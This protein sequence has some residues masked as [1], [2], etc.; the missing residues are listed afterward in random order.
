ML[1]R[2]AIGLLALLLASPA[3]AQTNVATNNLSATI[4]TGNTF[5]TI[6]GAATDPRRSLTIQN[7]NTNGDNCWVFLGS[8]AA[9]KARAIL[10]T[11][12][13]SYSRF[14]PYVP[15]D[16]VQATCASNS[17]TLYVETN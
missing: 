17:D 16:V 15:S 10:L 5:Q 12:G 1:Q 9:T 6:L 13:G 14:T 8:G 2:I 11:P 7:N 4:T 3:V